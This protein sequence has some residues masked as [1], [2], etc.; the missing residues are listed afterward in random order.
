MRLLGI[1]VVNT[2]VS[3]SVTV[4]LP[5]R[6]VHVRPRPDVSVIAQAS[7]PDEPLPPQQ[8]IAARMEL[9]GGVNDAVATVLTPA[10][11][12]DARAGDEASTTGVDAPDD[13]TS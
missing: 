12:A 9:P 4:A 13:F 3:W 10:P 11:V 7:V 6:C 1:V 8:T 2:N 5:A